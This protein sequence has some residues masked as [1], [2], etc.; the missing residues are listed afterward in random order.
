MVVCAPRHLPRHEWPRAATNAIAVN[1]DNRPPGLEDDEVPTGSEGERLALDVTRYWGE[2]GVHLTVG[3][4][5][6]PDRPCATGSCLHL[7]AWGKSANVA[8][9]E[10]ATDAAGAHRALDRAGGGSRRR[11]LLVEPR[12]RRPAHRPAPARP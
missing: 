1:P 11:R 5:D 12:H 8:F 9:V 4:I 3:F 6:T 7:N 2:D 10:S